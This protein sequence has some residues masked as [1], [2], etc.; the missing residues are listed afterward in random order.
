MQGFWLALRRSRAGMLG[1]IG[2][3][4]YTLL[5]TIGQALVPFDGQAK[6][7]QITAPPG[8]RMQLITRREDVTRWR[9]LAD[10]A[11]DP[12][13]PV[14][15]VVRNTAGPAMAAPYQERLA[16]HESRWR[17][18]RGV[19]DALDALLAGESDALLIFSTSVRR[20]IT[21]SNDAAQRERFS[22]LAVA[23]PA[24]G[25]RLWLGGDTQGR[26]ILSHIINGG[27]SLIIT[28]LLAGA[29]STLIAVLLGSI[30]ALAGGVVD[31]MLSALT[32]FILVIP[33]FPLLVVL[34][35]LIELNNIVLLA[36]LI[37]S[38]SWPPLMRALRSQ[39]LSLRERDYVEAAV[40]LDL[41]RTH[42][43][44][45]EILPNMVSFVVINLIFAVTGAMYEQVG[46]IF[47]GMAPINDYSWGV[48]LYF[49]RTRGTL[50][51]SDSAAMVLAPVFAIAFFQVSMVLFARAMEE[52]FDPRL[53]AA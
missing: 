49:G 33:R 6:L 3:L 24:L 14:L 15:G 28:A 30:A 17:S 2:L 12:E 7:D 36:V 51:S 47:L 31:R 29:I 13:Q 44:F 52:V 27:R 20:H 40:A 9:N 35:A 41:G 21:E 10:V 42:I 39:V 48:M 37:G 34:A 26:D 38:L 11:N 8:S 50:F 22:A 46:L 5:I 53:R 4:L 19:V 23:N 16:L 45:R 43:I 18:G 25:A 32:N 1:F